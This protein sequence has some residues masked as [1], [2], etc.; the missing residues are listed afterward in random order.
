VRSLANS[1]FDILA[2]QGEEMDEVFNRKS[3]HLTGW[4]F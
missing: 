1:D 3:C 2:E 4:E